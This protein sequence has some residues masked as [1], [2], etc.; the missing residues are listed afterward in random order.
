MKVSIHS[1]PVPMTA[2][3]STKTRIKD[4]ALKLFAEQGVGE[5]TTRDL[6]GAAG[7]AEGTI[8][9]HY[10]SKDDLARDLFKEYYAAFAERIGKAQDGQQGIRNKL[11]AIVR[12]ACAL[13]DE[14]PTLYRFLLLI[15]HEALQ[16]L[17]KG[18]A[19]PLG[20]MRAVVAEGIAAGE[21]RIKNPQLGASMVLGL[22]VQPALA[23]V[24]GSLK[25]PLGAYA[26]DIAE[27]SI[28]VLTR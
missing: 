3:H 9:R 7:I 22:L 5:T 20:A 2:E 16:R 6:A 4:A 28:R 1:Q 11:R 17:P 12:D 13:F 26:E 10:A 27:A 8:Y 25:A 21:V 24:H 14:N 19:N 18:G 15:Q 23:I